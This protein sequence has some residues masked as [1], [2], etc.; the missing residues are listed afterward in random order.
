METITIN[1]KVLKLKESATLAINQKAKKLRQ[2]GHTVYHWGFGES[3]FPV[4]TDVHHE[5]QNQAHHKEY[6]P[7]EGLLELRSSIQSFYKKNYNLDYDT[8]R[9]IIGPGSK[10]LLFQMIYLLDGNYIIPAP[11]WVSYGPQVHLKGKNFLTLQTLES[12]NY[13]LT[14][15]ILDE[16]CHT[17]DNAQKILILNSP[18]NPTGQYYSHDEIKELT[19]IFKKHKII[20]LADEIYGEINFEE[21][22]TPSIAQHYPEG[23][24]ITGGLSKAYS[25]GGYRLGFMNIPKELD[26]VISPLKAMISETFSAVAAPIQ[27]AAVKAWN[28]SELIQEEMN[29]CNMIHKLIGEY[30]Y[31]RLTKMNISTPKPQGAFYLFISFNHYKNKLSSLGIKTSQQLCEYLLE[32]CKIALLPGSDFYFNEED[33]KARLAYVDY[34]GKDILPHFRSSDTLDEKFI[35]NHFS[36]IVLGL[37]ELEAFLK[38]LK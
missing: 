7:T 22:L 36:Q 2:Q 4:M 33:L 21:K 3:P 11:S 26:I 10:E 5:L 14:P 38:E 9:I 20:V 6:L 31:K 16:Y 17:L 34:N 32:K 30:F 12:E 35:Q 29:K 15:Q 28:Q 25:A 19:P 37:D 1:E 18:S 13:K 27:Y 24:I 23:T 8:S